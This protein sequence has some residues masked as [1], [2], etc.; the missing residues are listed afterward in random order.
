MNCIEQAL[1]DS[2]FRGAIA[3]T[4]ERRMRAHVSDCETCRA[5]YRRRQIF[6]SLDPAALSPEERLGR[7]L[8]FGKPARR[9]AFPAVAALL[10]VAAVLFF[11][12]RPHDDGFT[13]RGN[14]LP[15]QSS[16]SVYR[17]GDRT[18]LSASGAVRRDDELA[19]SYR[20]DSKKPYVMI[21]GVDEKGAV[22]WF[23][24]AW[25][26]ESENPTA[27]KTDPAQ[28]TVQLPEAIKHPF[29][30]KQLNIHGVFLDQPLTV[31]EVEA[32]LR[33]NQGSSLGSVIPGA[34]DTVRMFEVGQ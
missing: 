30:G 24:P 14:V 10:A 2:H 8:G 11:V 16:I 5:H 21:F 1:I 7:G 33:K 3:P 26:N 23:Y 22:Y 9:L 15:L 27:L 12:I 17:V 29:A 13:A 32:D 6:A 28:T 34:I 20:N 18:L 19:F 25:T 4:D 31:R